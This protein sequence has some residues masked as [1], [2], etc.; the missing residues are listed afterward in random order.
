MRIARIDFLRGIAIIL[1]L[2]R[3]GDIEDNLLGRF[4]WLGV[5]LFFVISG[6]L[7]SGLLFKEYIDTGKIRINRF[8]FRRGFKIYPSFYFFM[9]VMFLIEWFRS[10]AVYPWKNI[11]AECVYLQNYFAGI[12]THTWSLAVEEHF[13]FS[14]AIAM[15]ISSRT[16]ILSYRKT[17]I[18][19]LLLL[20][21]VSFLLRFYI[22]Y[23]HRDEIF[24][25]TQTH[26]RSDGLIIGVLASYLYHYTDFYNSLARWKTS[27]FF[28]ALLLVLPGLYFEGGSVFMNTIGLTAANLGFGILIALAAEGTNNNGVIKNKVAMLPF[29]LICFIG[30]NS[31]SIYLWH[32]AAMDLANKITGPHN[33][34][35][36]YIFFLLSVTIG[37]VL[38]YS[39]EKPFLKLREMIPWVRR[40]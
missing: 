33:L 10:G 32:L 37:V 23:P 17:V 7:V 11:L 1:V 21:L 16:A 24:T 38:S 34:F 28:L 15:L 14:L 13:Y 29:K 39:I 22:S 9:M 5:D 36:F 3:H 20:L 4:G 35:H 31:Y 40:K 27:L 19:F 8:L 6:F 30:I 12:W 26:L 18:S 25:F 2:F